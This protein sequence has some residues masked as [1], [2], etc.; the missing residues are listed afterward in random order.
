MYKFDIKLHALFALFIFNL[1]AAAAQAGVLE[2]IVVTATK[3]ATVL[4][5]TSESVQAISAESLTR[6]GATDF[7][8]YFRLVPNLSQADNVGPGN[9]RYAIRGLSSAGEPLVSVYFDETPGLGSP[10]DS[11]DAGGSQPDLKLW[12]I[13]RIEILKGPQGTLYGNGSM[14]GTVRVISN[15]PDATE[16]DFAM[17]AGIGTIESGGEEYNVKGM[18]NIPLIQDKLAI[19]LT[20]YY[21][22]NDGFIDEQFLDKKDVNDEETIGGRFSIRWTPTDKI[23]LTSTF[24]TQKTETGANFEVYEGFSSEEDPTAGQLTNTPYDDEVQ[25]WNTTAEYS[26]DWADALYSFSLQDREVERYDDQTR[27]VLFGILTGFGFPAAFLCNDVTFVDGS[28][29]AAANGGPVGPIAPLNSYATERNIS[30]IHEFRLTSSHEGPFEW[31]LGVFHENR[32]S[33]REGQVA[34]TNAQGNLDFDN[35]G[36]A[37]NRV[38]ARNNRGDRKQWAVY[39]ELSYE[40]APS[41]TATVGLRWFDIKRFEA[42]NLV[43]NFGPGPTGFLPVET[44]SADDL[45]K[46]FKLSWDMNEDVLLY[47]LIAEGFRVGGPNQPVGFNASAP[48]FES[49]SLWNYELG[50]KTSWRDNTVNLNGAVFYIDWSDVQYETSDI[51]GAFDLIG[52]AGDAEVYGLE[53]ELQALVTDHLEVSAGLGYNHS[54]FDGS[55]P[56]QG[57]LTNQ[58]ADGDRIPGVPDWSISMLA[59]YTHHLS[60]QLLN[61]ANAILSADWAYRS[62]KTTGLRPTTVEFR[63]LDDYHQVNL[64]AGIT[65]EKWD[66]WLRVN[67]LFDVLPEISGRVVDFEPFKFATLQ[68]R[69]ISLSFGYRY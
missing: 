62:S 61:N 6:L 55:Q 67:N 18:A 68:P 20:G 26:F 51:S 57:Q 64:R 45:V 19:R 5:D 58:T 37:Q 48:P 40:F 60:G 41:W 54:R 3:R 30:R 12:D 32:D 17:E 33:Y 28:C 65:T 63:R 8:D 34:V 69:T 4:Q 2:E 46:R 47:A 11:V 66:V 43:Q 10:N 23:T 24:Y 52:N 35:T 38:F 59:Q 27:F 49:D 50:W 7:I 9:K 36:M 44:S 29:Y 53:L 42:Q 22:K 56:V 39:G 25:I 16:I 13:E 21:D 31:T 15:K 1:G 14:G